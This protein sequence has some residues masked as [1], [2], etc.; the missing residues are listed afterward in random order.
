MSIQDL[1]LNYLLKVQNFNMSNE[2]FQLSMQNNLYSI[3]KEST[4]KTSL[5]EENNLFSRE[6][7]RLK[8]EICDLYKLSTKSY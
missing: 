1:K 4:I 3:E 2:I 8:K 7:V 5:L 6:A